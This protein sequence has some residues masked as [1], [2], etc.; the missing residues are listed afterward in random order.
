MIS[1]TRYYLCRFGQSVAVLDRAFPSQAAAKIFQEE[2]HLAQFQIMR[3]EAILAWAR[4]RNAA[5]QL[6]G[7]KISC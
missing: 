5:I 1:R 6:V 2:H 3:G 7:L 4:E